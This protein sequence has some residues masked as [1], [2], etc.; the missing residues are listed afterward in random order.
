MLLAA[1]DE[2]QQMMLVAKPTVNYKCT[3]GPT[4]LMRLT[5][6]TRGMSSRLRRDTLFALCAVVDELPAYQQHYIG[7]WR[8]DAYYKQYISDDISDV[9]RMGNGMCRAETWL[10]VQI[11]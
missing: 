7:D 9:I 8:L 2:T 10:A 11:L 1:A 6:Q 5:E 3:E 4:S